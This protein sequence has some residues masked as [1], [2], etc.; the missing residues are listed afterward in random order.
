ML[1]NKS[2]YYLQNSWSKSISDFQLLYA[3]CIASADCVSAPMA[4]VEQENGVRDQGLKKY[5]VK[6]PWP[7][8]AAV[9]H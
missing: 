4:V 1:T 5:D 2:I 6:N 3:T 7:S 8:A 9:Q